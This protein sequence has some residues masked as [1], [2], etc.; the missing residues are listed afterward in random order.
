[1]SCKNFS[2]VSCKKR[3]THVDKWTHVLYQQL[4]MTEIYHKCITKKVFRYTLQYWPFSTR[5]IFLRIWFPL[6]SSLLTEYGLCS[7]PL[8]NKLYLVGGQTT[9]TDCYDAE[10]DE[11]RQMSAMKERRMECGAAIIN[12]CIYVTGGYSYSK[13]TYLQSVE[14]YDPELDTWEIVGNLP[15]ATRSHGCVCFYGV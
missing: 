9:I 8:D 15:T 6:L 7:V 13:G 1:M 2:F 14:K 10:R 5:Y 12:G 11:W 3:N 4:L